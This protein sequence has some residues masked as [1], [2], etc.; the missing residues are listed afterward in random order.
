MIW[1]LNRIP[2]HRREFAKACRNWRSEWQDVV[3]SDE[4]LFTSVLSSPMR[5][6]RVRGTRNDPENCLNQTHLSSVTVNVWGFVAYNFGVRVF[7][8]GPNFDTPKYLECVRDNFVDKYPELA[9]RMFLQDNASF[10]VTNDLKRFFRQQ[11]MRV[12]KLSPQSSDLNI[13]EN[14]WHLADRKLSHFLLTNYIN[15]EEDL[16]AK[17][18]EICES[19]PVKLVNDLFDSM[20]NRI[21]EVR[22]NRGKATHY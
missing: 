16:F 19:I 9:G 12:I 10:H 3:F 17:V 18:K 6:K 8:A 1:L 2:P 21:R 7:Y 15:R 14:I 22:A 4:K 20:P 13:Q 5:V 11:H